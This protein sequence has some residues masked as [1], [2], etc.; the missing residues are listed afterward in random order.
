MYS[1]K[2]CM[3]EALV[4]DIYI[5][6]ILFL[7]FCQTEALSVLSTLLNSLDQAANGNEILCKRF[8]PTSSTYEP[9]VTYGKERLAY[10]TML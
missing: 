4:L 9:S 10:G 7:P 5:E 1:V 2:E 8:N 6:N 3:Y